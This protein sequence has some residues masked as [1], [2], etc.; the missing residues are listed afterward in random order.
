MSL[1][2][3]AWFTGL[4]G[5][6]KSSIAVEAASLLSARGLSVEIVDG[7]VL[8]QSLARPLGFSAAD[9]MESNNIAVDVCA[10]L[11]RS[12]DVVLV[13]RISPLRLARQ[14]ARQELGEGFIEVYVKASIKTVERRDPKGLY[15][16]ARNAQGEVPIGLPGGLPFE[17]PEEADLILDTETSD[18]HSLSLALT[19]AIETLIQK[20]RLR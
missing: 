4:S 1:G 13:P 6:G 19:D 7:D 17:V 5:A 16:R 12:T 11:R 2:L 15:E 10:G 20:K 8:R 18:Q 9:V 3:V 14:I